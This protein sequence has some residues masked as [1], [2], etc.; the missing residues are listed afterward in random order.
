MHLESS[1]RFAPRSTAR[2]AVHRAAVL[3][4]LLV[5]LTLPSAAAAELVLSAAG[6]YFDPWEG[7]S[8]YEF[9]GSIMGQFGAG[10]HWRAGG[11][12]AYREFESDFFNVSGVD[13]DAYRI[14]GLFH[15]IFLPDSFLQP[16][17]GVKINLA[18]NVLDEDRIEAARPE[19]DVTGIGSGFGVGGIAGVDLALGDH[20]A[21][22]GE[23]VL[24]ADAQFTSESDDID[25]E[26]IGG[27]SGLGGVRI[28]F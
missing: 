11:E 9:R 28:K 12:F 8:G 10:G 7:D 27:F 16:Y 24:S 26:N 6:G 18:V 14:G 23:V 20:F 17:A 25:V 2:R 5:L 3:L 13:V 21:L 19:L 15:Y 22:F 1:P 4:C